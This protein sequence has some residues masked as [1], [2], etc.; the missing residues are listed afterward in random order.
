M[1]APPPD[2]PQVGVHVDKGALDAKIGSNAQALKKARIGLADLADWAAG[3]TAQQLVDLYGYTL[4]EA[5]LF[6]S[7]MTEVPSVVTLVDGLQWLSKTWG[8]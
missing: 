8:A 1:A 5:N 7:A 2:P 3:Y 6:K 4:D